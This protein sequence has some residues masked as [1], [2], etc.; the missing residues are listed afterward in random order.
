MKGLAPEMQVPLL[1]LNEAVPTGTVKIG[2][3]RGHIHVNG[4][5]LLHKRT[6]KMFHLKYFRL[7]FV[8][9]CYG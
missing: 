8:F 9:G 3:F 5:I 2:M 4:E 1:A 6:A 7:A